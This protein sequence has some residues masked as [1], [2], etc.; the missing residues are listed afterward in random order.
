MIYAV[1]GFVLLADKFG[2]LGIN[3]DLWTY[4]PVILIILGLA[5]FFSARAWTAPKGW[6]PDGLPEGES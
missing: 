5:T 4:W 3:F 6:N 1:V 2:L